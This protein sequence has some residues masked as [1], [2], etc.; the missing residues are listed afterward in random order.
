MH[1]RL[2][3]SSLIILVCFGCSALPLRPIVA[4]TN[5]PGKVSV[6]TVESTPTVQLTPP[7]PCDNPE[8]AE[9]TPIYQNS[10]IDQVQLETEVAGRVGF[11]SD[12]TRIFLNTSQGIYVLNASDAQVLCVIPNENASAY[13]MAVSQDGSLLVSTDIYGKIVIRNANNGLIVREMQAALYHPQNFNTWVELSDDGTLLVSSGYF[14]SVRVSDTKNGQVVL[15]SLGNHATISPDGKLLALRGSDYTQIIDIP[16]RATLVTKVDQEAEPSFLHLLFSRDGNYLYG[17][18]LY[19]EIKVWDIH[20]GEIVQTI[21]PYTATPCLDGPCLGWEV[22]SPRMTLSA[23]GSKLLLV[24]PSQ[25][26]LWNTETWEKIMSESNFDDRPLFD[27]AI[28]PDGKKIIV[29]FQGN[30]PIHFFYLDQ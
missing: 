24:D 22:E 19:S 15:E 20:T 16:H 27:A 1:K 7:S 17:L 30:E 2:I 11:S 5:T 9:I 8:P 4:P 6:V 26:I 12:S 10:R 13:G 18:N 14:Q 29:T 23:D 21:N 3:L 25:I 28:S